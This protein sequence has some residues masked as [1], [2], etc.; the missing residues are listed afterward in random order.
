MEQQVC[1]PFCERCA[2]TILHGHRKDRTSDGR[3][4]HNLVTVTGAP[5]FFWK[6]QR[7]CRLTGL[8]NLAL[9]VTKPGSVSDLSLLTHRL[10]SLL[11]R[12][13]QSRKQQARQM[14][15]S[16]TAHRR[17]G[18]QRTR[19][20]PCPLSE[21]TYHRCFMI[22]AILESY[23]ATSSCLSRKTKSQSEW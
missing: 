5:D 14:L 18:Q 4:A 19:V 7:I 23:S 16:V 22:M 12:S 17:P 13:Q 3:D 15:T 11:W 9:L 21:Q 8:V 6:R 1:E 2:D 20:L 10:V